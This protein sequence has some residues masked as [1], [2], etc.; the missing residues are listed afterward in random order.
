MRELELD[1]NRIT[2]DGAQTIHALLTGSKADYLRELDILDNLM[3]DAGLG[4]LQDAS[5]ARAAAARPIKVALAVRLL[6]WVAELV[7]LSA[8]LRQ[9]MQGIERACKLSSPYALE[10]HRSSC[11]VTSGATRPAG[12]DRG[13][14]RVLCR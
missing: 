12:I 6:S 13:S 14:R 1:H 4:L 2:D 9:C 8:F 5:Q 10:W 3:T 11:H 7:T